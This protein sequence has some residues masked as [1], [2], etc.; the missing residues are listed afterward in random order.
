MIRSA[1]RITLLL[2]FGCSLSTASV[3]VEL[4]LPDLVS[5]ADE[6]IIVGRV[7]D[8]RSYWN[9]ERSM[10]FTDATVLVVEGLGGKRKPGETVVFR[11]PGGRVGEVRAV[12]HGAPTFEIGAKVVVFASTWSDGALR[13]VGYFQGLS[14]VDDSAAGPP[15]LI[16]GTAGG[17]SLAELRRLVGGARGA[18]DVR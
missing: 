6:G 17:L 7:V 3:F 13:V 8:T 2:L 5:H 4:G 14:R 1:I 12:T 16:E 15:R 18:R 10:I 9:A 11:T